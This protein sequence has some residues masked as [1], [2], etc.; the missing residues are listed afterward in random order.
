MKKFEVVVHYEGAISYEVEA[1][2]E[3]EARQ[4]AERMFGDESNAIIAAEISDCDICD[5]WEM[6]EEL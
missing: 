2:T 1:Q 4:I 5:C 3:E 6:E